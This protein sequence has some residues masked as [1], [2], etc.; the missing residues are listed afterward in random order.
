MATGK[1][2]LEP[3]EQPDV[4]DGDVETTKVVPLTCHGHSRPVTHL[5]FS[6]LVED[7]QQY[8]LISSCKDNNPMMR[9][10][11]T[12]DWIGTFIGHKG[13]VWNSRLS[14]D[15]GLAATGSAD[16][17]AIVWNTY[18]GEAAHKLDHNHIVR[19]VAFP[20]QVNPQLLATGGQEK[21][22]LI[23]D[24]SQGTGSTETDAP[25]V[26]KSTSAPSYEVGKDAHQGT[27]KSIVWGPDPNIIVTA[28]ED[29]KVRWWDIRTQ[30][31]IGEY[32]LEG[33]IGSCELNPDPLE[34]QGSGVLSVAAGK[35]VYFFD[36][37]RPATLLKQFKSTHD[38]S[39]AALSGAQRKFVTGQS[40][41]T[42]VR[43]WDFDEESE[44]GKPSFPGWLARQ[45]VS[46]LTRE[47][48]IAKGHHGPVWSVAFSPDGKLFATGSEDGTIKLWK[49]TP[50]PY[51]LWR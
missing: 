13:A 20:P 36:G 18:T 14:A 51:G 41:D 40:G 22:L 4:E 17:S 50:G 15:A 33:M 49:F 26:L 25:G 5:S 3:L 32:T 30:S 10:G 44:L 43:I 48:E 31:T 8:Y 38:I 27:V 28:A 35:S 9:D 6:P 45:S 47:A 16:F 2:E 29:K 11:V 19:A 39:C 7:D 34:G 42:W 1:S 37:D 46:M 21:K 23:F 24:L 12:G